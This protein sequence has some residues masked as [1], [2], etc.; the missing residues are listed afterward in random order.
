MNHQ[1]G[2][3][4]LI[5]NAVIVWNTVYMNAA[6]ESLKSEGYPVANEDLR[7]LSPARYGHVNPYGRF[8]FEIEEESNRQQLRP[9]R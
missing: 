4:N 9:L 6:I 3:L 7:Y 1:A 5:T 8:I 2:C